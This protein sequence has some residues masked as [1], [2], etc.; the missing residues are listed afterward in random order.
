[1]NYE[2]RIETEEIP[3]SWTNYDQRGSLVDRRYHLHAVDVHLHDGRIIFPRI[4]REE[5][6]LYAHEGKYSEDGQ[7]LEDC[8]FE[9]DAVEADVAFIYT[10]SY[11][12]DDV[13]GGEYYEMEHRR[14]YVPSTGNIAAA[15]CRLLQSATRNLV[16][17]KIGFSQ[18]KEVVALTE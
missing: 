17:K 7:S 6:S 12:L 18:F 14:V 11:E 15:K 2:Y 1:M 8:L 10:S 16:A 9:N 4:G 3:S 5:E 13:S